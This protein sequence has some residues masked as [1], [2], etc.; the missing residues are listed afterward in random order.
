M[1]D[2]RARF[3]VLLIGEVGSD[4]E[5]ENHPGPTAKP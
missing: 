2:E 1:F 3:A 4:S 5:K